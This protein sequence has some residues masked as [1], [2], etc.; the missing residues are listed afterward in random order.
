MLD[1]T[2]RSAD[3][4]RGVN[5]A[6]DLKVTELSEANIGL[7]ESNRLKSE[8]LANV[9]HELKTPLNSIIGFAEL[10]DNWRP[11]ERSRPQAPSLPEQHRR[12][13]ATPARD[14]LRAPEMAKIEAGRI[15]LS[16]TP[17]SVTELLE[18]LQ[19]IMRPQAEDKRI[20]VEL[21]VRESIP[22]L[23]TDAGKLQQ[24]LFNFLSNAVKFSPE[25]SV[26]IISV[27]PHRRPDGS[28]GIRFRVTDHGPGVPRISR[29]RSSR[30][31]GRPTR[32]APEPTAGPS[33]VSRSAG[34]WRSCSAVRS[35][36]PS[37]RPGLDVHGGHAADVARAGL[38]PLID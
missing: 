5:E 24:I 21:Q 36:S 7:F 33:S 25:D 30:S 26:V 38:Q 20:A 4:L 16:I 31:S 1:E 29:S 27:E 2:V 11:G 8:F 10:L 28:A 19:A 32:A 34:S 17:V 37:G 6:L 14:D 22:V 18:G 9:S 35:H 13:R 3:R 15:E 23:E 12:E